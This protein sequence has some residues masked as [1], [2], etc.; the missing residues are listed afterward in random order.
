MA[1]RRTWG[2]PGLNL[3]KSLA[4]ARL[5]RVLYGRSAKRS[6][7]KVRWYH[8]SSGIHLQGFLL[9]YIFTKAQIRDISQELN[10]F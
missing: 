10:G 1:G 2:I 4:L 9:L 7:F 5:A 3:Q 6:I 8:S